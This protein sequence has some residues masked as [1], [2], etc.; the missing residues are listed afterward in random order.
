MS[1]MEQFQTKEVEVG[2]DTFILKKIKAL[3][4][5]RIQKKVYESGMISEDGVDVLKLDPEVIMEIVTQGC[6]KGSVTI[7]AKKFD[8]LFAG[9]ITAV[10]QL[11]SE[12]LMYNFFSEGEDEAASE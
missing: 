12:I 10:Y 8:T 3:P 9:K 7:D 6:T 2:G 5:L 4:A 11:V 1:N